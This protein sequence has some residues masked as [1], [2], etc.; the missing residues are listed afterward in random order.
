[1]AAMSMDATP[2]T[3]S[4]SPEVPADA[5]K[6]PAPAWEPLSLVERRVIGVL[7]EKQR[8]SKSDAE[9]LTLNALVTGCNQ[10]SNRDPVLDL[11]EG[12][13]DEAAKALQRRGLVTRVIMGRADRFRPEVASAWSLRILEQA[14]VA[15][16]LLRGPQTKGDLRVR[17]SRMNPINTLEELDDVLQPLVGRGLAVY[18]TEPER[19]GAIITHGFH[20]PEELTRLKAHHAHAPASVSGPDSPGPRPSALSDWE[21]RLAAALGEID[22][23]RARVASLES[24]VTDLRRQLDLPPA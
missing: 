18:L 4:A 7:V 5:P 2:P 3:P 1:M 21:G 10:K 19:R 9:A 8:T 24:Q 14:V 20:P 22:A 6:T 23:L 17:A 16:L 15:E 13:V 11:P 12:E